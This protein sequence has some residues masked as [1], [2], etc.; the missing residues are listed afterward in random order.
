MIIYECL[1][2]IHTALDAEAAVPFWGHEEFSG[3]DWVD[4]AS[5]LSVRSKDEKRLVRLMMCILLCGRSA[6]KLA[7]LK[8]CWMDGH[9]CVYVW[10]AALHWVRWK[11]ECIANQNNQSLFYFF[12]M[13]CSLLCRMQRA[14]PQHATEQGLSP[15]GSTS[16]IYCLFSSCSV[17]LIG[18]YGDSKPQ[19]AP[20]IER[21][22]RVSTACL[23]SGNK[24]R[25]RGHQREWKGE[26]MGLKSTDCF[27][28]PDSSAISVGRKT[29]RKLF[30]ELKLTLF[31]LQYPSI[32]KQ[33]W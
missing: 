6:L 4:T 33:M 32:K 26:V 12:L 24:G 21:E 18:L 27:G 20:V 1:S 22:W 5:G 23:L 10:M 29:D 2:H 17:L 25:V 11:E 14:D 30:K 9:H 7:N 31:L 16:P 13:L 3:N 15:Q 28:G 8:I 19:K